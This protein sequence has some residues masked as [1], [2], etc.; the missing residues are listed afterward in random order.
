VTV[1]RRYGESHLVKR[2]SCAAPTPLKPTPDIVKQ[3]TVPP[4]AGLQKYEI[5]H[6]TSP[7]ARRGRLG[8]GTS[9]LLGSSQ[10]E[11]KIFL[12]KRSD[13][14]GTER[15]RVDFVFNIPEGYPGQQN[16]P[17]SKV[18]RSKGRST[19]DALEV[20]SRGLQGLS[21]NAKRQSSGS[22]VSK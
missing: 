19:W 3:P 10:I 15:I 4:Y 7:M 18:E 6:L 9:P 2:P 21:L 17:M 16:R 14:Q 8:C 11:R 1:Q 22:L 12:A 5:S 13:R 20:V